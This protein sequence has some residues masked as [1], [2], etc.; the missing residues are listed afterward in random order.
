M[1]DPALYDVVRLSCAALLIAGAW[2]KLSAPAEFAEVVAGH[3]VA[4]RRFAKPL[5]RI[6]PLVEAAAAAA[7][8]ILRGP[9]LALSAA[10]LGGYALVLSVNILRG[11]AHVDCG[12]HAFGRRV[13]T[14]QWP[15]VARNM[16]LAAVAAVAALVGRSTRPMN[17]LDV[18]T[19][20]ASLAVLT[21]LYA[22]FDELL[23]LNSKSEAWRQG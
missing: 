21:L 4:P 2:H 1:L 18:L 20:V 19:I 6:V 7:V 14:L 13:V 17:P 15:M 5:A 12:C 23:A 11:R 22:S 16:A 3:A 8:I 10:L 9:G